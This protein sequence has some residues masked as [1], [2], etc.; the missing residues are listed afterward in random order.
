[1]IMKSVIGKNRSNDTIRSVK[2]HQTLQQRGHFTG[3][4]LDFSLL[5]VLNRLI[6]R[7]ETRL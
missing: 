5:L 4:T 1:M 6:C 2:S 7:L 3:G